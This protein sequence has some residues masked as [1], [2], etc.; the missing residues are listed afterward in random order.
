[1]AAWSWSDPAHDRPDDEATFLAELRRVAVP[2]R[3]R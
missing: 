3:S 1:M 2:A